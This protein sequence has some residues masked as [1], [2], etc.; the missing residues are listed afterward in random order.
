MGNDLSRLSSEHEKANAAP[1]PALEHIPQVKLEDESEPGLDDT[2]TSPL[3]PVA[4]PAQNTLESRRFK[5]E[6]SPIEAQLGEEHNTCTKRIKLEHEEVTHEAHV[7][8]QGAAIKQEHPAI[9]DAT[10][11]PTGMTAQ[12]AH[13]LPLLASSDRTE[14]EQISAADRAPAQADERGMPAVPGYQHCPHAG[15]SSEYRT[16]NQPIGVRQQLRNR[17]ARPCAVAVHEGQQACKTTNVYTCMIYCNLCNTD[18]CRN[19]FNEANDGAYKQFR[20]GHAKKA[21]REKRTRW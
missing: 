11:P 2:T 18:L 3:A 9:H 7:P 17:Q 19:C 20:Y 10:L 4:S 14:R 12:A 6:G 1:A 8:E 5:R 21:R 16:L 15:I 13:P